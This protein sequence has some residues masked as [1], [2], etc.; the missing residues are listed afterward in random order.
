MYG[1]GGYVNEQ[2][3]SGDAAL[4]LDTPAQVLG[5]SNSLSRESQNQLLDRNIQIAAI[6]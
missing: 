1:W 5:Q 4:T 3:N 6:G 2:P